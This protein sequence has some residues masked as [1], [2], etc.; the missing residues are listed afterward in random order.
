MSF[1]CR[2]LLDHRW[3]GE[4]LREFVCVESNPEYVRIGMRIM[5]EAT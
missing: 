2:N 1:A 5:P 3:N 4:R